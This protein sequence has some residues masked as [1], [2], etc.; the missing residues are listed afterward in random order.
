MNICHV[1]SSIDKNAGGT[2]TYEQTILNE[3]VKYISV[4]LITI[5][6]SDPITIN[7]KVNLYTANKS[8]SYLNIL[9]NELENIFEQLDCDL[10]H[11]NGLWQYPVHIMALKAKQKN[12]P[13]IISPHGM[14]EPWALSNKSLKKKIALSLYQAKDLEN[15]NC[16]HALSEY[17]LKNIRKLKLNNP[18]AIIP[19][20][21]DINKFTPAHIIEPKLINVV[22]FL[23]RIHP[24]KGVD[25]LIEA[26]SQIEVK[27]R[28]NWCLRIIGNGEPN[29]VNRLQKLIKNK[30]L[31]G[32]IIL[33]GPKFDQDKLY[34]FQNS[35]LFVLP[36]YSEGFPMALIESLACGLPAITTKGVP[37]KELVLNKAGWWIDIGIGPLAKALTEA[38]QLSDFERKQMGLNGRKL[39]EENY[40]IQSVAE[41]MIQLYEWILYKKEKPEFVY[42][43]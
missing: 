20:G 39:V 22:L 23:S 25:L 29:Y 35:D 7:A 6:S 9:S 13:Y 42:I 30:S 1:I 8:I 3:L 12:K 41:K 4:N 19:N 31:T 18:I 16:I 40:S 28:K 37:F 26:W 33:A 2:S 15:A 34:E 38:M 43:N 24:K 11:G 10:Y 36:S 27:I 21:I 17:E 5:K 32:E 14:L